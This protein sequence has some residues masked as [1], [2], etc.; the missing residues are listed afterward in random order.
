MAEK[1]AEALKVKLAAAEARLDVTQK[2]S[3]EKSRVMMEKAVVRESAEN[4]ERSRGEASVPPASV[5]PTMKSSLHEA[6]LKQIQV[7]MEVKKREYM[8]KINELQKELLEARHELGTFQQKVRSDERSGA[9][10]KSLPSEGVNIRRFN[11]LL[12]LCALTLFPTQSMRPTPP[13]TTRFARLRPSSRHLCS[14][15]RAWE[16]STR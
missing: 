16:R 9:S 11:T 14:S 3:D 6:E 10:R 7:E 5:P 13:F 15:R 1:E 8:H 2:L 4:L 12:V